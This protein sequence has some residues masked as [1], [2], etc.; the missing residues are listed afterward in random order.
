MQD[1]LAGMVDVY[2]YFGCVLLPPLP[3]TLT[4]GRCMW[5]GGSLQNVAHFDKILGVLIQI[6]EVQVCLK[7]SGAHLRSCKNHPK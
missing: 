7:L 3:H 6:S 1:D 4:V 2:F 5:V